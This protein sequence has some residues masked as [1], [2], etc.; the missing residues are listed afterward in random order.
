MDDLPDQDFKAT[1]LAALSLGETRLLGSSVHFFESIDSTNIY[2]AKL[3]R[4]GAKE[5][6]IVVADAQ[7]GGKGRLGRSWVSPPR[8]N[9]YLSA[10]LRPDKPAASAP[11]LSLLAA[12]AVAEA[13]AEQTSVTPS[14]KWPNDVLVS[15]KKVCGILTE[16]QAKDQLL[17]SVVVGIGV[18]VNAPLDMFPQELHDKATSL[19]LV[20]GNPVD[21]PAFTGRLLTHLEKFYI[22]WLEE[23]FPAVVSAWEG[24]AAE[25]LGKPITVAAPDGIISGVALGIDH[26]GALLVQPEGPGGR[27]EKP[28]RV[29]AG[30]VTVVGGYRRTNDAR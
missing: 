10:I 9:L 24:H 30:D 11:Q 19:L 20:S 17:K 16:M 8:V 26:D 12:V 13:V 28:R 27:E 3:A 29:V 23:G 15:G 22:L 7:T 25:L 4:E 2:A 5:G 18:N 6:T 21:R 1:L 14:I